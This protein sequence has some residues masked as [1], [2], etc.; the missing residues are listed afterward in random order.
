MQ[1]AHDALDQIAWAVQVVREGVTT[2]II[3]L[4]DGGPFLKP[5]GNVLTFGIHSLGIQDDGQPSVSDIG[6][7][8]SMRKMQGGDKLI[9]SA[10]STAAGVVQ[11]T[12]VVQ[13]FCKS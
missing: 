9:F 12:G 7:T 8:K 4:S 1:T 6:H 3:A 13:F 10:K 5:E 11:L 2:P